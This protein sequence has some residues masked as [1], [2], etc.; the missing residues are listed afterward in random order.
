MSIHSAQNGAAGLELFKRCHPDIVL[1]DI[2]M[3]ILNG[4]QMARKIR[5]LNPRVDIIAATAFSDTHYLMDAINVGI[6]RY[7]MKPVNFKL[8][9]DAIED[10]LV[11]IGMERL[12]KERN[13][14]IRKLSSAVQQSPSMVIVCDVAGT[15]EYVNPKFTAITGYDPYE[16]I[17]QNLRSL[18]TNASPL[19]TF[20]S[21]WSAVSGGSEWRGEIINRKKSGELY[22]E[23]IS[24]S[25]LAEDDGTITHYVAVMEDISQRKHTEEALRESEYLIK[26]SQSATCIGSYKASFGTGLWESSEVL[27]QILGIDKSYPRNLQG[28]QNLVHP[29]DR[30]ALDGFLKEEV[31]A[32]RKSINKE[33]RIIRNSDQQV[34]RVNGLGRLDFDAEGNLTSMI[35]T[36]QDVTDSKHAIEE[37]AQ[38]HTLCNL[39]PVGIFRTDW[40]GNNIYANPRWEEITGL[41][42][43]EALGKGWLRG[44]PPDDSERIGKAWLKAIVTGQRYCLEHRLITPGG[45]IVWV[46]A[47]ASGIKGTNGQTS[48]FIGTLEDITGLRTTVPS[49]KGRTAGAAHLPR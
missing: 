15:I 8:L 34:R 26:Q 32:N 6:N 9:F 18:M 36:I 46:R 16:V 40:E 49:R 37:L 22:C 44:I 30:K 23:E 4:I 7:V 10:C 33:F 2:S 17:D 43:A 29:D 25:P 5:A 19:D 39:A 28:W 24:I 48:S 3:P 45:K 35:G 41:S 21:I 20:E 1:T 31:L 42:A 47:T 12:L 11:R 27:D 13:D 14:L 38:F